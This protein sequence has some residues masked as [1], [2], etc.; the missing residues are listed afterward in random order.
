M[1]QGSSGREEELL[2]DTLI[3]PENDNFGNLT[4]GGVVRGARQSTRCRDLWAA[5]LFYGRF[6]GVGVAAGALG[7]PA[8]RR[9]VDNS[10]GSSSLLLGSNNADY[11]E[12]LYSESSGDGGDDQR[13]TH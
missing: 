7:M 13:D 6:V 11:T 3:D 10:R 1:G 9:A 5:T 2:Q 8:V 12:L 4:Y